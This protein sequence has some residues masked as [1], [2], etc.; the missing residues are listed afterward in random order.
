KGDQ[1]GYV[2]G[3]YRL[4]YKIASGSFGRVFRAADPLTGRIVA[5]KILRKRW[6]EDPHNIELFER[7]GR[8]GLS[9]RHLNIVEILAVSRDGATGQ[10]YIVMEFVEGGNLRDFLSIRKKLEPGEAVRLIEEAVAGLSYA[11]S[12]GLTHRDI[13][14]TNIL[15]STQGEAKLVDFGLAA[16]EASRGVGAA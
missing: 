8:V 12:K 2:L 4:L 3:G 7:E 6:S 14:L 15:I 10:Y 13:K 11:Y 16:M 5:I 1:D 9:L